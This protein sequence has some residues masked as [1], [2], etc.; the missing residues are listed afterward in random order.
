[1]KVT[2]GKRG[3]VLKV[4]PDGDL[5]VSVGTMTFTFNP[6]C[7]H[8]VRPDVN[9]GNAA[10][11]YTSSIDGVMISLMS[12]SFAHPVLATQKLKKVVVVLFLTVNSFLLL[13]V[14][15]RGKLCNNQKR[16]KNDNPFCH[17]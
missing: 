8:V 14:F 2:M 6:A 16:K 4:Y 7:C 12:C 10:I 15:L 3:K 9:T 17:F 5:R 13:F 11:L 1:M